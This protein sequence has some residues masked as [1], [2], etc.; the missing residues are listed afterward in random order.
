MVSALVKG[1]LKKDGV[2]YQLAISHVGGYI[3]KEGGKARDEM[4]NRVV[5]MGGDVLI[6]D[7]MWWALD[8]AESRR[9][10]WE[11][12]EFIFQPEIRQR[13]EQIFRSNRNSSSSFP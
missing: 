1:D 8:D 11:S 6:A 10:R 7:L 2:I 3:W 9:R 4:L 13:V 12:V 5:R